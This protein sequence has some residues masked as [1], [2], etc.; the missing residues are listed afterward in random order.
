M[1][2]RIDLSLLLACYNEAPLFATSIERIISVLNISRLTYELIF[3]DDKSSDGTATLIQTILKKH[4]KWKAVYHK[5]NMGR[6]RSVCDGIRKAR[7][8]VVGFV[9]VDLEVSPVYISYMVHLILTG[10]YDVI[11]GERIYRTTFTSILREVLS[12]G[13]RWLADKMVAT[14]GL[15]TESGYKFFHRKKI[16]PILKCTRHKRWFWDTEIVVF[17]RR[18]GLRIAEVPVLFLRRFDKQ[19]SVHLVS[20]GIEYARSLWE[21]WHRLL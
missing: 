17:C 1:R 6:G 9:D 3:I 14:G 7:G 20:D 5:I 10:A 19:S 11:I 15:D 2:K 21:L 18:A 8:T 4:P 16:L 12:R 13:Y